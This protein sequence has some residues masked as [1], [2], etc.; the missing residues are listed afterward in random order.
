MK[1]PILKSA[2]C[3]NCRKPW[4]DTKRIR[5]MTKEFGEV[6]QRVCRYCGCDTI[7][8]KRFRYSRIKV[9]A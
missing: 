8:Y 7:H 9:L 5:C 4:V 1:I 6:G 2:I 3:S